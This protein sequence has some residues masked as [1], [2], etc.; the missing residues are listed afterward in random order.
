MSCIFIYIL[1]VL[2]IFRLGGP[3]M[4]PPVVYA[5]IPEIGQVI[6]DLPLWNVFV[7]GPPV[8][9]GWKPGYRFRWY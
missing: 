4:A 1:S 5:Q 8:I 9:Y 7:N 2:A 6:I 3:H